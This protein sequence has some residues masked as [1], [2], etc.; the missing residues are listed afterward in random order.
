[1]T[2]QG[3]D[4]WRGRPALHASGAGANSLVRVPFLPGVR[5]PGVL[6]FSWW[7]DALNTRA[8]VRDTRHNDVCL[9]WVLSFDG[10]RSVFTARDRAMSELALLLTG[11]PLPHATLMYIWDAHLPAGSVLPH[12]NTSR[13]R[14]VV[15]QSGA[16]GLGRW[17]EHRRHVADDFARAFDEPRGALQ[18]LAAFTNSNNTGH[19][20]QA[21][22]G[23]VTLS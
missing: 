21:W 12:P 9:R 22:Y 15:V 23:P 11:E 4:D 17:S 10:D 3:M 2:Y 18:A 1:M 20:T 14:F 8:D 16:D 6:A 5:E 13:I 19:P 7:T